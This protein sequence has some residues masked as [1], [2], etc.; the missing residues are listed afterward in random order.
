MM[1][2]R[3]TRL[4]GNV[5]PFRASMLLCIAFGILGTLIAGFLAVAAV[6]ALAYRR[7]LRGA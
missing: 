6:V 3:Q 4:I 7:A 5:I 2:E 1:K